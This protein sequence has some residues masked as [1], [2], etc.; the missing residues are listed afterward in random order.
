M[1]AV[2]VVW[3]SEH[4]FVIRK[5]LYSMETPSDTE[6]AFLNGGRIDDHSRNGIEFSSRRP[7]PNECNP[8]QQLAAAGLLQHLVERNPRTLLWTFKPIYTQSVM[9][10]MAARLGKIAG[11]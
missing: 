11:R 6:H 7:L 2:I 4:M 3:A 9:T 10:R 1:R 5:G 8:P